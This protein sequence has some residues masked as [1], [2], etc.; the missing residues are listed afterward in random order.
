MFQGWA[1]RHS[2]GMAAVSE[3]GERLRVTESYQ[4]S[5]KQTLQSHHVPNA[6]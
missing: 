3:A 5:Q 1:G 2:P 4:Q 6:V